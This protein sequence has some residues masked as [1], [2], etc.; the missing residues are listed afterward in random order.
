[1]AD[2]LHLIAQFILGSHN[3]QVFID[4]VL[5]VS[6]LALSAQI[7]RLLYFLLARHV[8]HAGGWKCFAIVLFVAVGYAYLR[9]ARFGLP[10]SYA[11]PCAAVMALF[12]IGYFGDIPFWRALIIT[13]FFMGLSGGLLYGSTMLVDRY[14]PDRWTLERQFSLVEDS[15]KGAIDPNSPG[16][17]I[18]EIFA[19]AWESIAFLKDDKQQEL[20]K[21]QLDSGLAVLAASREMATNQMIMME[22]MDQYAKLEAEG[23]T[24][25]PASDGKLTMDDFRAAYTTLH[26]LQLEKQNGPP[27]DVGDA[28][29]YL[30]ENMQP[31]GAAGQVYSI[32]DNLT[33]AT[34]GMA[35]SRTNHALAASSSKAALES[36]GQLMAIAAG[37]SD[38]NA[39]A[40]TS[41]AIGPML[42]K[43]SA[44]VGALLA[45]ASGIKEPTRV[46]PAV[47]PD[48]ET[49]APSLGMGLLMA[50][51]TNMPTAKYASDAS[52][53]LSTEKA[54]PVADPEAASVIDLATAM[55]LMSGVPRDQV[56]GGSGL[57]LAA[58]KSDRVA[59]LASPLS[60]VLSLS[61][62]P[63]KAPSQDDIHALL[64]IQ[65]KVAVSPSFSY[66]STNTNQIAATSAAT[67]AAPVVAKKVAP[68]KVYLKTP[69]ELKINGVVS[70]GG[71]SGYVLCNGK[72]VRIGA[73]VPIKQTN[74]TTV[75]WKL[76]A[77]EDSQPGWSKKIKKGSGSDT[78]YIGQGSSSSPAPAK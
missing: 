16:T 75:V 9:S 11:A 3:F 7:L 8:A 32:V 15:V 14:I 59:A 28:A 53:W 78:I 4:V 50:A 73:S 68:K 36:M 20:L 49:T 56:Q 54:K 18:K 24:G 41:A 47:E 19:K 26:E 71:N 48:P 76:E 29:E 5:L 65:A 55:A 22:S 27:P 12:G 66:L 74:G 13:P 1:M 6:F 60:K 77:I 35:M 67:N 23:K 25:L 44:N 34:V 38:T 17:K 2:K 40:G 61:V 63:D 30:W 42:P 46:G 64:K 31:T 33:K 43:P 69:P 10:V 39:A 72:V 70:A 21:G 57:L 62:R 52:R 58:N 45:L 51:K 37:I